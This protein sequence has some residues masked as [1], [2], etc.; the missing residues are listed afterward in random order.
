M[1]QALQSVYPQKKLLLRERLEILRSAHAILREG[2]AAHRP[3]HQALDWVR[4]ACTLE[5]SPVN[6]SASRN[7]GASALIDLQ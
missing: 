6:C 7:D 5:D 2:Y 1:P 3:A 4:M